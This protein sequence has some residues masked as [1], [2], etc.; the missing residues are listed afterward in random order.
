M[1]RKAI[2]EAEPKAAKSKTSERRSF[3]QASIIAAA[4]E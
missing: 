4:A 2:S 3:L 1:L